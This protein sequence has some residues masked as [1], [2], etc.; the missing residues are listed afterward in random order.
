MTRPSPSTPEQRKVH[1]PWNPALDELEQRI[2]GHRILQVIG[3]RVRRNRRKVLALSIPR[4]TCPG[5]FA[6]IYD[7]AAEQ[8][9]CCDCYPQRKR[10]EANQ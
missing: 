10:Y 6:A 2:R 4:H 5:C 1:P 3:W 7:G 9:W 8:G